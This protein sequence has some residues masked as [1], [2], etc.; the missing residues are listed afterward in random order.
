M[1]YYIIILCSVITLDA[2]SQSL[3]PRVGLSMSTI[4]MGEGFVG[5]DYKTESRTG[6]VVGPEG[7]YHFSERFGLV[8]SLLY[9]QKGWK[10][11]AKFNTVDYKE[12]IRLDYLDLAVMPSLKVKPFYFMAGPVVGIGIGGR[13]ERTEYYSNQPMTSTGKPSFDNRLNF[14]GQLVLGVII[15]KRTYVD[16][17]Y[18]KSFNNF[19]DSIDDTPSR[20]NTVQVTTGFLLNNKKPLK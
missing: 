3:V 2:A 6:I 8:L 15:L 16:V 1:N 20:L 18:Q 5:P 10:G 12:Q 14:A 11:S 19:F 17:R 7:E 13:T 9:C 4:D